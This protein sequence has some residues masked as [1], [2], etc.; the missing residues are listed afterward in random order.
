MIEGA[1]DEEIRS[2]LNWAAIMP[3]RRERGEASLDLVVLETVGGNMGR[4]KKPKLPTAGD[5]FAFPLGN[6]MFS[7][8]RVLLDTTSEPAKAWD[9]SAIYVA[10]SA[11]MGQQVPAAGDP[12]LRPILHVTHHFCPDE[13]NALWVWMSLRA[14]SYPLGRSSQRPKNKTAR[15]WHTDVGSTSWMNR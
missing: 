11:W 13:P 10:G 14:S 2:W 6:G 5:D 3:P 9:R 4:K 1:P 12:A 15:G 7:V 8:C